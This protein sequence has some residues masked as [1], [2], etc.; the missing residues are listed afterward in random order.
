MIL[1]IKKKEF[2]NKTGKEIMLLSTL[3]KKL[4]SS[5]KAKIIKYVS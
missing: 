5:I 2:K 3:N 1:M 4:V